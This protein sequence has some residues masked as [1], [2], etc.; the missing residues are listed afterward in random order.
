M[1]AKSAFSLELKEFDM[2]SIKEPANCLWVGKRRTGKSFCVR[3]F[4]WHHQDIP[5]CT[6]I[7][8][9]E[10]SNEFYK[11]L[12]PPMLIHPDYKP[13]IITNVLERQQRVIEKKQRGGPKYANMDERQ[14]LIMDDLMHN[15]KDW[16]KDQNIRYISMNGRH[17]K[18]FWVLTMQYVFG[19]PPAFRTNIDYVFIM[20]ENIHQNKKRLYDAF[21]GM[22]PTL[23][24]FSL[25]LDRVTENY[26]CMVIAN[27]SRSNNLTDQVFWYRAK[28]RPSFRLCSPVLWRHQ[29]KVGKDVSVRKAPGTP[30]GGDEMAKLRNKRVPPIALRLTGED[31]Q[32]NNGPTFGS[33]SSSSS[34]SSSYS[35]STAIVPY[36][37]HSSR[38]VPTF[39]SSGTPFLASNQPLLLSKPLQANDLRR[40]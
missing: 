6:V 31:D 24:M 21:C 19:L 35:G 39:V 36:G 22:F 14:I 17:K 26:G 9:S 33:S 2:S 23:E 20:R 5:V 34:S 15:V 4:L 29:D 16:I 18:L 32:K 1:A 27:C 3:D 11:E 12:V 38:P 30:L 8:G 28:T 40:L 10:D 25:V 7:S 13:E 37:S